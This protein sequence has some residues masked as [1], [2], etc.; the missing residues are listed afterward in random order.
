MS[1]RDIRVKKRNG[2]LAPLRLQEIQDKLTKLATGLKVAPSVVALSVC[3]SLTDGISTSLI[4]EI[5]A[6]ISMEFFTTH[7]DYER[8]AIRLLIDNMH[9]NVSQTFTECMER[10]HS[11]GRLSDQFM[12]FV[13]CLPDLNDIVDRESDFGLSFFGLKTLINNKYLIRDLNDNVSE[14]PCYMLLRV[15]IGIHSS[16]TTH[17][18]DSFDEIVQIYRE[19][20]NRRYTHATPTLFNAG[21][22]NCQFASCFLLSLN[23]DSVE[24]IYST[25]AECALIS[26]HA[27]GIGLHVHNLRSTGSIIKSTGCKTD[28]LMPMLRVFNESSLLV[29]QAGKRPG[30]IAIYLSPDHADVESFIDM[31]LNHGE[32]SQRCRDL[33]SGLWIP[34]RFMRA[35][36]KNETWHLFS[37][38]DAPG[39]SDVF[40]KEYDELYDRY[41]SEGKFRKEIMAQELWNKIVTSQIETGTPYMTY[42]DAANSHSNQ[43]NI[44]VIKSSNLCTEIMEVSTPEE[45]AVCNLASICVSQ[46][47]LK[48]YNG[49]LHECFDFR[50]LQHTTRMVVKALNKVID[51]TLYPHEKTRI[52]NM[53]HRPIGIGVQGWQTLL[54]KLKLSFDSDAAKMLNKKLFAHMYYAAWEESALLVSEYG[55]YSSFIGSPLQ[56][57]ILHCDTWTDMLDPD[58]DWSALRSK[59]MNGVVNSLITTI[60]PTAST[61]QICGNTEACEPLTSNIYIRRTQAGEFEQVNRYLV[62]DLETLGLW[63][64]S[65]RTA[66]V[67]NEGSIQSIDGIPDEI[68]ER[69]R[70]A[71]EISQRIIIEQARDRAPYIDQSQSMNLFMYDPTIERVSSM[72]MYAW[73]KGLKTGQ[74]YLRSRPRVRAQQFTVEPQACESCSA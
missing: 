22:T 15:A 43:S 46:F 74:Y 29:K 70:T 55:C 57:G 54:F 64:S 45:T 35:V 59:V 72:H 13:R 21:T 16:Q 67:R 52:S 30:S 41:V 65:V 60:M 37:P 49:S 7:T 68:K 9:R 6:E 58:L 25:L 61:A 10:L 32:E 12:E 38:D 17:P 63:N 48:P 3:D 14:L 18:S 8:L 42:K 73:R 26:K 62:K 53:R 20:V 56:K 44:G 66:I 71:F 34:D 33:F 1:P 5:C 40:G 27:G 36:S 24:G 47:D 28:G 51:N 11:C 50:S 69:Y 19:L 39:L 23:D 2:E 4:D 31:R